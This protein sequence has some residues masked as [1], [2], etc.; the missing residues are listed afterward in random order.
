MTKAF[1]KTRAIWLLLVVTVLGGASCGI[2]KHRIAVYPGGLNFPLVKDTSLSFKGR[3]ISPVRERGGTYIYSTENGFVRCV[4]GLKKQEIWTFE[5]D[6]GLRTAPFLGKGNVYIHDKAN[7]LYSLDSQG[8][9]SWKKTVGE[10][11]LT[12][13]VEESGRI[14]FG[15]DKGILWSLDLEGEDPRRFKAGAT[16]GAG[17][18]VLGSLVIFGSDDGKLSLIDPQGQ[19]LGG[20]QAPGKILGP[21]AS[22]GKI[23]FFGTETRDFLGLSLSRL[24]PKWKVRLGGWVEIDPV[25]RGERLFLLS[26]NSVVYCLKKTSGDIL[27]WQNIPSRTAYELAV[28]EDKVVVST[29]SS[30]LLVFDVMTGQKIGEYKT[31]HDLK[32]NALWIDPFLIIAHY[33][34]RTDEGRFVYLKKDVQ[35]L[36][37]AQ[38]ASPQSVGD[39]I[40]FVASAVG[41]FKPNYEFYLKTGEK[42]EVVQ[43]A[44]EEDSWTW[45]ADAVG[46]YSVGVNV[47]D[48]KQSKGIEIPF[49]IEKRPD[50]I[51][52]TPLMKGKDTKT[53]YMDAVGDYS[54]GIY[55]TDEK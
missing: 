21:M 35:A 37:S 34:L 20:F 42:R 10:R 16:V 41:F 45:Y 15:T 26:T 31:E 55:L 25:L 19:N 12:S 1:M 49:I 38:K 6:N 32:A 39:E 50:K 44:S 29:L 13:I 11:I 48:E 46:S 8:K 33:D 24:K 30:D 53:W 17:P 54:E 40:V 47:T 5:S 7:I 2:F 9:L 51:V 4:D 27:W 52:E 36:L 43:K 14:Y 23:V 28:I 18:L 22:D 3:I